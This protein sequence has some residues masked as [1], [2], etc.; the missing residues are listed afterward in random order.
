MKLLV[1]RQNGVVKNSKLYT[2]RNAGTL[3][4]RSYEDER[5][6]AMRHC[7]SGIDHVFI[8]CNYSLQL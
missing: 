2:M 3:L 5:C 1:L 8:V 4:H 6:Y 7:L